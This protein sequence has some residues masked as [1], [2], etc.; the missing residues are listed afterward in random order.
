MWY[1][2]W[3]CISFL[4][5]LSISDRQE[6]REKLGEVL[7]DKVVHIIEAMNKHE[8]VPKTPNLQDL[9]LVFDISYPDIQP[10]LFRVSFQKFSFLYYCFIYIHSW[11]EFQLLN[12]LSQYPFPSTI[13]IFAWIRFDLS[14]KLT[15]FF[16]FFFLFLFFFFL[17]QRCQLFI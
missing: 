6:Q 5:N 2:S 13:F 12:C 10:Y 15:F 16:F 17:K 4:G 8:Y 3:L 9:D 11:M 7:S 1:N 14:L